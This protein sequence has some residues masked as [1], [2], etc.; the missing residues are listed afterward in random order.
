MATEII[1]RLV[2]DLDGSQADGTVRF[3]WEGVEYELDLSQGNA[4]KFHSDIEKYISAARRASRGA[5]PH[6]K[7]GKAPKNL[8]PAQREQLE[9]VRTWARSQGHE[10]S[11]RGRVPA[12]IM[13]LFREAHQPTASLPKRPAKKAEPAGIFSGSDT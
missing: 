2:D 13:E 11:S 4:E 3:G 7:S 8:P 12:A 6:K 5:T 9:A 10:V 1:K